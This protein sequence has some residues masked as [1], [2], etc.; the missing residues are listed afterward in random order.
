VSEEATLLRGSRVMLDLEQ[1]QVWSM[2]G[3]M[4]SLLWE[5]D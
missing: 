4:V 5:C 1:G 3:V 2:M